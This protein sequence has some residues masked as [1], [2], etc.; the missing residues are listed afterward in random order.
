MTTN[1]FLRTKKIIYFY[2]VSIIQLNK[3][4]QF[5]INYLC[6]VYGIQIQFFYNYFPNW[7]TLKIANMFL[8]YKSYLIQITD[9]LFLIKPLIKDCKNILVG[10][11]VMS[12]DFVSF[13][14]LRIFLYKKIHFFIKT[15]SLMFQTFVL[16]ID[17]D[18][19]EVLIKIKETDLF[20]RQK[21]GRTSFF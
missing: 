20:R 2:L 11:I 9:Y 14:D 15:L 4:I 3:K 19:E 18:S 6:I 8:Y 21:P 7:Y 13:K 12:I 5:F 10:P 1:Q 16:Q 17:E